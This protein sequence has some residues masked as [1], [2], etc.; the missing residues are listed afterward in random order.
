MAELAER[1]NKAQ[2]AKPPLRAMVRPA[3][4]PL[5][6]AQRRLW[7][8]DRLEGPSPTYNIPVSAALER[9]A[10]SWPSWRLPL[11]IWSSATRALRTLLCRALGLFST[12]ILEPARAQ[13]RLEV[14]PATRSG[15][16]LGAQRRR[17]LLTLIWALDPAASH[18][19]HLGAESNRCFCSWFTISRPTAGR[20]CRWA[21]TWPS[22]RG[23]LEGCRAQLPVLPVQYADYTLWQQ[24]ILGRRDATRRAPLADSWLSGNRRWKVCL[25]NWS[26]PPIGPGR[27]SP[28]TGARGSRC[29]SV[30][31]CTAGCLLW[32]MT[33][34]PACLWCLQA[35]VA[36]L[37]TRLGA[38][39]DIPIGS[40]IAGRTDIGLEELVGFFVNTLV[41]RTDTSANPSFRELLARVRDTDLA[42]YAHQDL[43]FER[44]VELLNPARSLAR[45]PLFQVMLAFQNTPETSARAA[46]HHRYV[47]A[48]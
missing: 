14:V 42:A 15:L 34:R 48:S 21:A 22:L 31:S 37:L 13:P 25:N 29:R 18:S 40:P 4:I 24:Q 32:L 27:R 39:T 3:Q 17:A 9:R 35:G 45:H 28:V 2:A 11:A 44:L 46:R 36:A 10:G 12:R 16:L 20:C 6:F 5:S 7:F 38:G 1:L 30:Q 26:Y 8:L 23:A 33:I 41:L 47:G 19:F 43:P